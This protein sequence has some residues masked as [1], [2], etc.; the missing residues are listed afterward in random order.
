MRYLGI[1]FQA[2][3]AV[4]NHATTWP[5]DPA[6]AAPG[7]KVFL[8]PTYASKVVPNSVARGDDRYL[9]V[10]SIPASQTTNWCSP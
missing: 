7:V 5:A 3:V 2:A 4:S 6:S 1:P 9:K 8:L 10:V